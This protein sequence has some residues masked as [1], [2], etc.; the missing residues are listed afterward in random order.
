MLKCLIR[1]LCGRTL[2]PVFLQVLLALWGRLPASDL[3]RL[4]RM[5]ALWRLP[6]QCPRVEV[7]AAVATRALAAPRLRMGLPCDR[8]QRPLAWRRLPQPCLSVRL[9]VGVE[10]R[11]LAVSCQRMGPLCSRMAVLQQAANPVLG[12][13]NA[14]LDS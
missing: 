10:E 5:L 4:Q 2:L 3:P 12:P 9:L 8:M 7:L 14:V 6:H 11:M 13:G 1:S